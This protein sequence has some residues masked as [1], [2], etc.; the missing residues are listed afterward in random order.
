MVSTFYIPNLMRFVKDDNIRQF[1]DSTNKELLEEG[2]EAKQI[3]LI[4]QKGHRFIRDNIW[5]L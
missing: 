4:V 1:I 2:Q 5:I 3:K